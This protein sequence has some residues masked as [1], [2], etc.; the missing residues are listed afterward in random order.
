[1][2]LK[3]RYHE[4]HHFFNKL[5]TLWISIIPRLWARQQRGTMLLVDRLS[6]KLWQNLTTS[7][8]VSG[9]LV[10][11]VGHTRD[12]DKDSLWVMQPLLRTLRPKAFVQPL[13]TIVKQI[14]FDS[15]IIK[16]LPQH[17]VLLPI[18]TLSGAMLKS[19]LC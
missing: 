9:Q 18:L 19:P 3:L 5:S 4:S 17:I 1:M 13:M 10:C 11:R 16:G 2:P 14:A 8:N 12:L 15:Y 6:S 7:S